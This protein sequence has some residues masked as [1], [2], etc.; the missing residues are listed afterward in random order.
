MA[1]A[2]AQ[3]QQRLMMQ[4]KRSGHEISVRICY[5][6]YFFSRDNCSRDKKIKISFFVQP[7]SLLTKK[8]NTIALEIKDFFSR[9]I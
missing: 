5:L 7:V 8:I 3:S 2:K 1:V 9:L 4:P 6:K